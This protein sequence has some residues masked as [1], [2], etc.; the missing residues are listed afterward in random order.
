MKTRQFSTARI[1]LMAF[2]LLGISQLSAQTLILQAPEPAGNP[3]FGNK[4]NENQ[5]TKICASASFNQYYAIIDWAGSPNSGNEWI[6]ELSDANGDFT[7]AVEL[8]RES[9]DAL[10][11]NPGFEFQISTDTRGAGYKM[12]VRST[13]PAETSPESPAYP[14]Y[15]LGYDSNLHISPN[16]DGTTPGTVSVCD[17]GDVTLTVDN[18]PAGDINT[19]QYIWYRS[20]TV[21]GTAPSIQTSGSGEYFVFIDYGDCTNNANTES[22]HIIISTGTS[23]GIAINTPAST[24]LCAGD[25]VP[26]L[27]ANVQDAGYNY[28]WY[29]DGVEVRAEQAGGFSYAIDTNDPSFTGDY[30][31]RVRAAGICTETSAPVSIANAG[32]FTVT[33]GN[34]ANMVVL[35][36]QTQ[37][38]SVSTDANTPTYIWYRNGTVIPGANNSTLDITQD[39]TYYAS[40]TQTG[41]ACSSTTINS[42]TTE[43]V[44]P[45][46]FR[47][48]I[49]YATAYEECSSTSIVLEADKI[50][51]VLADATEIEVTADVANSFTYQW[52]KNGSNITGETSR[53]ISLTDSNENGD[54]LLDGSLGGLN[55]TSNTL[56][57]QLGSNAT[58]A[59]TSTSTV[60]CSASDIITISTSTDLNGESFDWERDG[61][62]INSSDT[63]L[64]VTEPGTYRLA[65]R[66]GTCPLISNEISITP[67]NPDLITLDVDGD[68]IFPEGSSKTV[69]ASGGTAYR[70]LDANNIEIGNTSS[71]TFTT[72]GSYL[73]IANIDDCEV[74]KPITVSYLDLF[75]IPNVI[76]PNGDGANDQWIIP[77][78]YSNKSDV[79]VIIYNAQGAEV[80]NA[81]NYQNNW[82]E[83]STKFSK[84]NMV[85]YY[86]IK[87]A[88]ETLKQGTITVIR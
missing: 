19:Y 63:T 37:T 25:T 82:P 67:L 72:E 27:E 83:S 47:L 39:G 55:T 42:E 17:S 43:V 88:T 6:L 71:I 8:G 84:Q 45:T 11:Q 10:V 69:T 24:T 22:N 15:Y 3:N 14:M 51:A 4:P 31:V 54:Y 65:I 5:W 33:R 35:P 38:L 28:T 41:G 70:W 52:R 34:S 73:L 75:N 21:V 59:I 60:Y 58:L 48:E 12:R 49:A 85:F 2:L 53:S 78:S 57:V 18:I 44:S 36:G 26:D 81:M 61:T 29:K 80:L 32:E 1:L 62:I 9:D 66:K 77:N 40:V 86:V 74:S 23:T 87:N 56:P 50:Y 30:T 76:T 16:G 7:N 13:D 20:G 68:V 79:N 64:T 46:N